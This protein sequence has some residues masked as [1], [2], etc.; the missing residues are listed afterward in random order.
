MD[1]LHPK[2]REGGRAVGLAVMVAMAVD[3]EGKREVLGLLFD[4]DPIPAGT[5]MD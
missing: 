1:A 5:E 3:A 2:A 4:G